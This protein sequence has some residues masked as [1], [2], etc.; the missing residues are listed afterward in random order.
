VI[1]TAKSW[2]EIGILATATL[3]LSVILAWFAYITNEMRHQADDRDRRVAEYFRYVHRRDQVWEPH[4][5]AIPVPQDG[6]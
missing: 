5:L 1:L 6:L 2:A 4:I 3:F